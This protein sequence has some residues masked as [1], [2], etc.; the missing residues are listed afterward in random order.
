MRNLE[1]TCAFREL[2]F[3][4]LLKSHRS[5]VGPTV[6][7]REVAEAMT[8]MKKTLKLKKLN[9]EALK[10]TVAAAK[11]GQSATPTAAPKPYYSSY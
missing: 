6:A 8:T 4:K 11:L 9:P 5:K 10:E 3:C 1:T 2:Y 7:L